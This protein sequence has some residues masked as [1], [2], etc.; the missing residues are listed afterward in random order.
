MN[1]RQIF[2]KVK[3]HLLT[4]KVRS[5][6]PNCSCAYRGEN[7]TMCAVGCLIDDE[8]YSESLERK[9]V[10]DEGVLK[11]LA[12]SGI[13]VNQI[14]TITLLSSLQ[15]IHDNLNPDQWETALQNLDVW[16]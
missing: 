1:Q 10:H 12:K 14:G 4:Q 16:S 7:G 3:N 2:E 8:H 15:Y 5:S 9:A 13:I 11:A 6:T